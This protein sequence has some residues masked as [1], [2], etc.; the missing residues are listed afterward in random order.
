MSLSP[1]SRV[2]ILRPV[3]QSE[4]SCGET[5]IMRAISAR[6]PRFWLHQAKSS[7]RKRSEAFSG[8]GGSMLT[9][10]DFSRIFCILSLQYI[11][12]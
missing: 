4:T 1:S 5:F 3:T 7:A 12:L 8:I 6:R 2:G 11:R 9:A 10:E